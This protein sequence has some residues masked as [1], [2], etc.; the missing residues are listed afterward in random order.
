[1]EEEEI[2]K[3]IEAN[4]TYLTDMF[5]EKGWTNMGDYFTEFLIQERGWSFKRLA[6]YDSSF[7]EEAKKERQAR[8]RK[9]LMKSL[10]EAG[11]IRE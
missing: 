1:L 4:E 3:F 5:M 11:I 7:E 8:K 10:A 6:K 9:K 2:E